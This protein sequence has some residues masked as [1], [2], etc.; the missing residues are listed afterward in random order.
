MGLKKP[1]LSTNLPSLGLR[2]SAT[3]IWKKGLF[4][5]PDLARRI[6]NIN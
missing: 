5:A 6:V 3:V 4:L 1:T 2:E